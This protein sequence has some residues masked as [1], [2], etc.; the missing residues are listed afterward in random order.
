MRTRSLFYLYHMK[1]SKINSKDGWC[2][3]LHYIKCTF[4]NF[5]PIVPRIF[6]KWSSNNDVTLLLIIF[7]NT[8]LW[9]RFFLIRRCQYV[10]IVIT[11]S[12]IPPSPQHVTS[13]L[14]DH[15]PEQ[16]DEASTYVNVPRS[17]Q[18]DINRSMTYLYSIYIH[19]DGDRTIIT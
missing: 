15:L 12:L 4:F 19:F 2:T 9:S 10:S 14:D 17:Q 3:Q 11:K 8:Q 1:V 16:M 13:F 6:S 5:Y 7:T 18:S